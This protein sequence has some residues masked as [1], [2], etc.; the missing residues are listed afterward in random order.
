MLLD[1]SVWALSNLKE[2]K[3]QKNSVMTLGVVICIFGLVCICLCFSPSLSRGGAVFCVPK[4]CR[5]RLLIGWNPGGCWLV[6][7]I[8]L[9]HS[10]MEPA[11]DLTSH[12]TPHSLSLRSLEWFSDYCKLAAHCCR[13]FVSLFVHIVNI[14]NIVKI[15]YSV[16]VSR[17]E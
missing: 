2:L 16:Q 5:W 3:A 13:D 15:L 8:W 10:N 12:L 14:V 11:A 7:S 4:R 1:H 17:A 9:R 6:E